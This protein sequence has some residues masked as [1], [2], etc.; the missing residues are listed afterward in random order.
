VTDSTVTGSDEQEDSL[1]WSLTKTGWS[2][3][4]CV[5]EVEDMGDDPECQYYYTTY[6]DVFHTTPRCPHIQH[7]ENLHVASTRSS[8][9]GPLRAGANR[10]VGATD[11][12]CDLRECGWCEQNSGYHNLEHPNRDRRADKDKGASSGE[13]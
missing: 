12:W 1:R 2:I 9:N 13:H 11:E 4:D 7:S 5:R 10:V 3:E 8:L 6:S